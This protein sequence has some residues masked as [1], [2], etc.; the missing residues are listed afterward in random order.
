MNDKIV[1]GIDLGTTFSSIAYLDENGKPVIIPN[2]ENER[3]TPSV[4]EIGRA[5]CRERV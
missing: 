5:S 2:A 3:L 4:V 1:A